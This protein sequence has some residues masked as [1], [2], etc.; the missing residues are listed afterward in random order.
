MRLFLM[1]AYCHNSDPWNP[2]LTELIRRLEWRG[3]QVDVGIAQDVVLQPAQMLM[4]YDLFVLKSHSNLWLSLAGVLHGQG[5]RILNPY[6]SC[7]AVQNK[8]VAIQRMQAT[9]IPIPDT[10]VTGDLNL[11]RPI[12]AQKPLIVKPYIGGRGAGL[13]MV[14]HPDELT[15]I[16]PPKEPVLVQEFVPGSGED[17]K[18]YVIH[19][20]VF[21]VRKPFSPNSY[22]V[23][24]RP[25]PVSAQVREIALNCG[26]AFG[27]GLYGL[28]IIEGPNGPVVVDL[29]YFPSYKGIPGAADILSEYIVNYA[30][31][32]R[33]DLVLDE[34][35]PAAV[36]IG[37]S[38]ASMTNPVQM[39]RRKESS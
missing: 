2:V 23:S 24:G 32:E 39:I 22:L 4:L 15:A 6:P 11:L 7:M 28:D 25:C 35:L 20:Q 14:R 31:G 13:Y 37:Y 36:P 16:P 8:I 38:I 19:D 21:A 30:Y 5:A 12:A 27:L 3:V 9:G 34:T 33:P 17:L 1:L 26:K 29:N 10:W 18:V